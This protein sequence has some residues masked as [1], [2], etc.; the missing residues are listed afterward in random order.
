M[1]A[2]PC[3]GTYYPSNTFLREELMSKISRVMGFAALLLCPLMAFAGPAEDIKPYLTESTVGVIHVDFAKIDFAVAEKSMAGA[4][5]NNP[6]I[7]ADQKEKIKEGLK[8]SLD[9]PKKWIQSMRDA[10]ATQ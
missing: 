1:S 3:F 6:Q 5:D 10:G 4:I 9:T 7:P 2:F 8:S